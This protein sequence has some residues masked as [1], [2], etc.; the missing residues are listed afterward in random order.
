MTDGCRVASIEND[1]RDIPVKRKS[2]NDWNTLLP[3]GSE[4]AP[5]AI[6]QMLLRIFP[7]A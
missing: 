5:A 4:Y 7:E 3:S 6:T 1:T 2:L